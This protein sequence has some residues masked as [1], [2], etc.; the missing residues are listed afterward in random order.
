APLEGH[1]AV[2]RINPD[3][4]YRRVADQRSPGDRARIV[5]GHEAPPAPKPF[6]D[7]TLERRPGDERR[8]QRRGGIAGRTPMPPERHR[9]GSFDG[10]VA[11]TERGVP[12]ASLAR[13]A[14]FDA[15]QERGL[16]GIDLH[17]RLAQVEPGDAIDLRELPDTSRP[18]RPLH[19]ERVAHGGLGVEIPLDR[20]SQDALAGLL[21]DL[22]ELARWTPRQRMPR[23]LLELAPGDGQ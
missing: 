2:G 15:V 11:L 8:G 19:L 4:W 14:P 17:A 20:P 16:C 18:G 7:A 3:R 9:F 23:L 6:P 12:E 1:G 21:T 5:H 13:V 10:G 22:A